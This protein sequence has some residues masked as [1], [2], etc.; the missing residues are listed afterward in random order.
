MERLGRKAAREFGGFRFETEPT[1]TAALA[2]LLKWKIDQCRR[3]GM[4]CNYGLPWVVRLFERLLGQA[5]PEFGGTMFSL[6][7]GDRLAAAST[8]SALT[9]SR[10][11]DG[12]LA[13]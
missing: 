7:F 11:A 2:T 8:G 12:H 4:P 1:D 6:Y 9:E 3:T 10:A 5:S 13:D